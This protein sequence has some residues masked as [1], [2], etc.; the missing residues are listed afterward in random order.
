MK[1]FSVGDHAD[2]FLLRRWLHLLPVV[3]VNFQI[4]H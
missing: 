2:D 4:P 1:L 3:E